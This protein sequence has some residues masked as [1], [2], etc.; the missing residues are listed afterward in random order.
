MLKAVCVSVTM[1]LRAHPIRPVTSTLRCRCTERCIYTTKMPIPINI[2][3]LKAA[4]GFFLDLFIKGSQGDFVAREPKYQLVG[5][6]VA[7]YLFFAD[8]G[9]KG[10]NHKPLD[11]L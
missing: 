7:V 8:R 4:N 10:V 6:F 5:G 3:Y 2:G 9:A 11:D 1:K